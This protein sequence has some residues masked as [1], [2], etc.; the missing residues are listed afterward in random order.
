MTVFQQWYSFYLLEVTALP[1]DM[2]DLSDI[3]AR[4]AKQLTGP[5]IRITVDEN[6]VIQYATE[7]KR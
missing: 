4:L 5:V 7:D 3:I 6:S 1:T 2:D